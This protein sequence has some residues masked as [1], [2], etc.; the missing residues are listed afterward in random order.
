MLVLL[1]VLVSA[2]SGKPKAT[3]TPTPASSTPTPTVAPTTPVASRGDWPV[4]H[5]DP[6]R[7]GVAGDQAALGNVHRAWSSQ[8]LDG[9]VYAQP[10]VVGDRIFV[11]T[12]GDS[13]YALEAATGRVIWRASLGTPVPQSALPCGNINPSGITGTP[14]I[15]VKGQTLY[16]VA[17]LRTGPRHVLFALDLRTGAS[18]WHRTID[19][20][21]LSAKVE[22]ERGALALAN[23]RVYVPFGGLFGDCG[24][25]KGAVVSIRMD[26]IGA[27]TTYVVP[28]RREAGIWNPAGPV[29]DSGGDVWVST[30]NS[31]SRSTFDYGNAVVR[32]SPQLRA[33]DYFAPSDWVRLNNG[34]V[35]L[36]SVAPV[37][38]PGGRA[39]AAGK[40]GTAYLLNRNDLGHIGGEIAR[41]HICTRAFGTV[42]TLG[43]MVFVPCEDALVALRIRSNRLVH[44]WTSFGESGPP[45]IAAG[46]VWSVRSDGRITALDPKTGKKRFESSISRPV[47]RFVTTAAANGRIFVPEGNK[48]TAFALR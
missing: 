21:G 40:A 37:L 8:V 31:D 48:I 20:P 3:P 25:Y 43:S 12:Q 47:S 45:I 34:D 4:Y 10:L 32:L 7:T 26:G 15:D 1:A 9:Q 17:F 27:L 6:A 33:R 2:C 28:T 11:A 39:F 22:Q 13:V 16:V 42:A 46:A 41:L 23:G 44:A 19:P 5:H 14:V 24:P 18:R 38:L 35:D 36:G 30:G 29:V